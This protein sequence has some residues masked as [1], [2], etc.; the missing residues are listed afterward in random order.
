MIVVLFRGMLVDSVVPVVSTNTAL[1]YK[2]EDTAVY[3]L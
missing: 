3:L 2:D 1:A